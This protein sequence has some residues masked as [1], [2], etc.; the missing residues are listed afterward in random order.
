MIPAVGYSVAV[1]ALLFGVV[2]QRRGWWLPAR[3][4]YGVAGPVAGLTTGHTIDGTWLSLW[5]LL[6]LAFTVLVWWLGRAQTAWMGRLGTV[7]H[8]D[9]GFGVVPAGAT[10]VPHDDTRGEITT[11]VVFDRQGHRVS[12]AQF[13]AHRSE[14]PGV[15]EGG[16]LDEAITLVDATYSMVQLRTPAVPAVVVA[17]TAAEAAPFEDAAA[18][19]NRFGAVRPAGP[20]EPV[21]G[22]VALGERFTVHA[23]NPDAA[24][25]LLT[26]AVQQHIA[27]DPWF[28]THPVALADG[29]LWTTTAGRLTESA[30]LIDARHLARLAAVL[31]WP[32]EDFATLAATADT[33][34]R[35][36]FAGHPRLTHTIND[37]RLA[38]GKPPLSTSA[39][40]T[41][42]LTYL[43]ITALLAGVVSV[44][45]TAAIAAAATGAAALWTYL[46]TTLLPKKRPKP[47]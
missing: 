32:D 26:P 20:L 19:R 1:L 34:T 23:A 46:R 9:P 29:A 37:R 44:S 12:A 13:V 7:V 17:P 16:R 24:R 40:A 21:T 41:R 30:T 11:G 25:L 4:A 38:A 8:G 42:T 6:P 2:A 39:L 33:S 10:A 15:P 14:R 31:P 47:Q 45:A 43:A 18:T 3:V 27:D 28:R 22:A 35:T 36:W 5:T